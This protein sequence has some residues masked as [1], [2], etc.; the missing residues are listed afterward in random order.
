MKK[1]K[2][3][4]LS[5]IVLLFILF[6][7]F[8][9]YKSIEGI[10]INRC[11]FFCSGNASQM[12]YGWQVTKYYLILGSLILFPIIIIATLVYFVVDLIKLLI[13][14]K[15]SNRIKKTNITIDIFASAFS[16]CLA[17]VSIYT[18]IRYINLI[19]K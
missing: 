2:K 5:I 8:V 18:L 10:R 13:N 1:S 9:V 11:L 4:I 3:I 16:L 12:I 6:I 15:Y 7:G 17:S 19:N 14:Q